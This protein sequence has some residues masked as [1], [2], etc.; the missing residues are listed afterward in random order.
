MK[1]FNR[2][3]CTGAVRNVAIDKF[4][5]KVIVTGTYAFEWSITIEDCYCGTTTTTYKSGAAARAAFLDL[6]RR[7]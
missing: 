2:A 1:K 7:R 6:M 3:N 4:G 5:R